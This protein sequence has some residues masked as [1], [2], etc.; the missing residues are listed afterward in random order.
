MNNL[1]ENLKDQIVGYFLDEKIS[2]I[3]LDKDTEFEIFKMVEY[4][5][6]KLKEDIEE[7][8]DEVDTEIEQALEPSDYEYDLEQDNAQRLRDLA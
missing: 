8:N 7:L 4:Y 1:I 2:Q 5:T 6:N 3:D